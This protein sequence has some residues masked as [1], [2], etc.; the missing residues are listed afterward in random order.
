MS[1]LRLHAS[2][3]AFD[4]AGRWRAVLIEGAPG[5]GKT[6]LALRLIDGGARLVADDQVLLER[7]GDVLMARPPAAIMGLME[8]A[9]LGI[10]RLP[11]LAAAPVA[12]AVALLPAGEPPAPVPPAR[13][14]TF[15][16]HTVPELRL[17]AFEASAPAKVRLA[18]RLLDSPLSEGVTF[19]FALQ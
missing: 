16:G 7:E 11:S 6:D 1:A 13:F 15:P 10:V 9:G 14:R 18:L 12:L 17:A 3:V 5:S 19:P 8:V 2:A 4:I